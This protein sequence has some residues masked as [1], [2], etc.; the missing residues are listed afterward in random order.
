MAVTYGMDIKG[1]RAASDKLCRQR[2]SRFIA[3]GVVAA[4]RA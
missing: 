1:P 3:G 2:E 4:V